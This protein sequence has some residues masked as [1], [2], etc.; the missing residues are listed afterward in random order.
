MMPYY[1]ANGITIYHADNRDV[2]PMRLEGV[3]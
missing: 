3:A 2:L 1:D